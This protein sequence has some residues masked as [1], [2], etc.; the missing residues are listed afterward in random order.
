MKEEL[1]EDLKEE[2][3]CIKKIIEVDNA[4]TILIVARCYMQPTLHTTHNVTIIH[5][6]NFMIEVEISCSSEQM[7]HELFQL[8]ESYTNTRDPR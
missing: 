5:V 2:I 6:T 4:E 1:I 8:L 3:Q 7:H